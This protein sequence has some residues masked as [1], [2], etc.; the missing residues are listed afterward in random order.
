VFC[1]EFSRNVPVSLMMIFVMT[2]H[3][4]AIQSDGE[5]A[6]KKPPAPAIARPANIM[7][8]VCAPVHRALPTRKMK[9]ADCI[10][11]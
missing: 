9:I 3:P 1:V 7:P 5:P 4:A 2:K 10:T 6:G 11:A 8:H